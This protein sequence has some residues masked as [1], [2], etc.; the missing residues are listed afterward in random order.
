MRY[1]SVASPESHHEQYWKPG[2]IISYTFSCPALT[3]QNVCC[4]KVI[5][6]STACTVLT[7]NYGKHPRQYDG[8][9]CLPVW[10][11]QVR[12]SEDSK[13]E[14]L[15]KYRQYFIPEN[16]IRMNFSILTQKTE[17]K[18]R[19]FIIITWTV[20]SYLN[21]MILKT[22]VCTPDNHNCQGMRLFYYVVIIIIVGFIVP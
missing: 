18:T 5:F 12:Q 15:E 10:G 22:H 20:I 6:G 16:P 21:N 13:E 11:N 7:E 17:W 2:F 8:C 4:E 14:S 3:C 1:S 9:C 19:D